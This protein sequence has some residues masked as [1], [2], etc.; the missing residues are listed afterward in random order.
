MKTGCLMDKKSVLF[1]TWLFELF[2]PKLFVEDSNYTVILPN[3]L[4]I[5]LISR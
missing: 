3:L 4:Q 5:A 2:E 1:K